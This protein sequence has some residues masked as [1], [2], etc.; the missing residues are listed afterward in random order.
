[1]SET[2]LYE[3]VASL[4]VMPSLLWG[5]SQVSL[6]FAIEKCGE[7]GNYATL[8]TIPSSS[9]LLHGLQQNIFYHWIFNVSNMM[10]AL[11][12]Q[13]LLTIRDH[14]VFSRFCVAQS[15][16]VC[17]VISFYRPMLVFIIFFFCFVCPPLIF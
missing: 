6:F 10:Y 13:K 9:Y 14:P 8:D 3:A 15:L 4:P 7:L 5:R 12:E 11:M 17:V 1:M 16:V 2:C